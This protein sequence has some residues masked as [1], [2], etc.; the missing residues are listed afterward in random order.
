[1]RTHNIIRGCRNLM[2]DLI[3]NRA[4]LVT[5]RDFQDGP[6]SRIFFQCQLRNRFLSLI[7]RIFKNLNCP[8]PWYLFGKNSFSSGT[9]KIVSRMTPQHA[10]GSRAPIR[11]AGNLSLRILPRMYAKSLSEINN[12]GERAR[13]SRPTE[14]AVWLTK[15]RLL[16]NW[17]LEKVQIHA[18]S[19]GYVIILATNL[20]SSSSQHGMLHLVLAL[21]TVLSLLLMGQNMFYQ[22]CLSSVGLG[23][24][25]ADA[26]Q[27]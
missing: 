10:N 2:D 17:S 16:A 25:R 24:G 18:E 23:H 7:S 6:S 27:K 14:V 15:T 1:M 13:I 22:V 4:N 12:C 19:R 20:L 26:F 8:S 5:D 9:H 21:T 11:W 3:G